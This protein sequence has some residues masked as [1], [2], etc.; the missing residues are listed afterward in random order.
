MNGSSLMGFWDKRGRRNGFYG[1]WRGLRS[2]GDRRGWWFIRLM[3]TWLIS[4]RFRWWVIDLWWNIDILKYSR[5]GILRYPFT[6][7]KHGHER[8]DNKRGDDLAKEDVCGKGFPN[9]VGTY[10]GN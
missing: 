9:R 4:V 10:D 1:R 6:Q 2:R 5:P 3:F 8:E 7:K